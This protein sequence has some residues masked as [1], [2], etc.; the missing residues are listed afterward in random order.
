M[1]GKEAS[2]QETPKCSAGIDVGKSW[3]DVHVLPAGQS[4]RVPN[5]RQGIAQLKRWLMRFKPDLVTV[6]ATGKWHRALCRSLHASGIA[7]S[8][9]VPYRVRMFAKAQGI[10]A[11]TDRLDARVLAQFAAVMAPSRYT[12]AP[13]LLEELQELVTARNSAVGEE[14]SLKNQLAVAE[15][16]FLK[17]QLARRILRLK[18]DLKALEAQ[19]RKRIDT[20]QG[21]AKRYEILT[22]IPG[23]G[24]KIAITLIACLGEL[25]S[26]NAKQIGML[27]GLAPVADDS[28]Q[29]QGARTI[30]GGRAGVRKMLYLA[31]VSAARCNPP[32]KAFYQRLA[33]QKPVKV[34]LVATARKLVLLAN[35]LIAANRV[36]QSNAP[37]PA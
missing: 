12:P 31:A 33:A 35:T 15:T 22:S 18:A 24:A 32:L 8:V 16:A 2:E 30:R 26:L 34:A 23:I 14:T 4:L 27:S 1:Q 25:G 19:C 7:V 37:A 9:A 17:R 13:H 36:W 29:H 10:L 11:K 5:T 6:E 3:L 28:G 21:L 20:D